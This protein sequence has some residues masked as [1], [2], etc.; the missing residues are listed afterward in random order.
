MRL[1]VLNSLGQEVRVLVDA[2]LPSGR[3]QSVWKGRDDAGR[4]LGS[5]LYFYQ[6]QS[7]AFKAMQRMLLLK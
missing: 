3:Y 1:V 7:E 6:L 4:A 5:G 2:V